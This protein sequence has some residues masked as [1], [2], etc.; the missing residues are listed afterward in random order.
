MAIEWAQWK[1]QAES[2][3]N[4]RQIRSDGET[5]SRKRIFGFHSVE[6]L[7]RKRLDN[8]KDFN[9]NLGSLSD[10]QK[11]LVAEFGRAVGQAVFNQVF[12][13]KIQYARPISASDIRL[14]D[15]LGK[16]L[17]R[18][19]EWLASLDGRENAEK[20]LS[21]VFHDVLIEDVSRL[22]PEKLTQLGEQVSDR[23]QIAK[24]LLEDDRRSA[25]QVEIGG[26]LQNKEVLTSYLRAAILL[27]G[28]DR[29]AF[30]EDVRTRF[31]VN[32][33]H[34]LTGSAA[35]TQSIHKQIEA[36]IT[37]YEVATAL[38][39]TEA[40]LMVRQAALA[41]SV[42][43]L[44]QEKDEVSQ[45]LGQ[46]TERQAEK[47]AAH[48]QSHEQ[49][50]LK[51]TALKELEAQIKAFDVEDK[52]HSEEFQRQLQPSFARLEA[53]SK[54]VAD[55]AAEAELLQHEQSELRNQTTLAL[56]QL[57]ERLEKLDA[58]SAAEK[59]NVKKI[60]KA[61]AKLEADYQKVVKELS[62]KI[63]A[64]D[65]TP[66]KGS[67]YSKGQRLDILHQRLDNASLEKQQI[68]LFI[69]DQVQKRTSSEQAD[70]QSSKLADLQQSLYAAQKEYR[71]LTEQVRADAQVVQFA[72]T[73][74][75]QMSQQLVEVIQKLSVQ[76]A[77][78]GLVEHELS[79]VRQQEA[80]EGAKLQ[81]AVGGGVG[82]DT[83]LTDVVTEMVADH[84]KISLIFSGRLDAATLEQPELE[85]L[86]VATDQ[87]LLDHPVFMSAS[88]SP[89][90]RLSRSRIEEALL[91]QLSSERLALIGLGDTITQEQKIRLDQLNSLL[92]R[93]PELPLPT[94]LKADELVKHRALE[95]EARVHLA[96]ALSEIRTG[97]SAAEAALAIPF[98]AELRRALHQLLA[99]RQMGGL[100]P[101]NTNL[102]AEQAL[103]DALEETAL[104]PLF[105]NDIRQTGQISV[106]RYQE[107][108]TEK[109]GEAAEILE[110]RNEAT[111]ALTN[112]RNLYAQNNQQSTSVITEQTRSEAEQALIS[113][114]EITDELKAKHEQVQEAQRLLQKRIQ[115][116]QKLEH[117]DDSSPEYLKLY[118]PFLEQA[119]RDH[120]AAVLAQKINPQEVDPIEEVSKQ[121]ILSQ[122]L[123]AKAHAVLSGAHSEGAAN[124]GDALDTRNVAVT[125]SRLGFKTNRTL[126]DG[127]CFYH[128][129]A[130]Q[131]TTPLTVA[132]LRTQVADDAQ[133]VLDALIKNPKGLPP[134]LLYELTPAQ[135]Q[136]TRTE[137]SA[138]SSSAEQIASWGE[139][140]H[141]AYVARVTNRPVVIFT[142][143]QGMLVY[144]KGQPQR[145]LNYAVRSDI[146]HNAILLAHNGSDHWE[147]VSLAENQLPA[148]APGTVL[149]GAPSTDT[150]GI[151]EAEAKRKLDE[152]LKK[153]EQ[154]SD[155]LAIRARYLNPPAL[156]APTDKTPAG[157][158]A[159]LSSG[160][161]DVGQL[162]IKELQGFLS[163][164]GTVSEDVTVPADPKRALE[165]TAFKLAKDALV[166]KVQT[167]LSRT[168]R[169]IADNKQQL[170]QSGWNSSAAVT[171]ARLEAFLLRDK[172]ARDNL[173]ALES[174]RKQLAALEFEREELLKIINDSYEVGKANRHEY[175]LGASLSLL[176]TKKDYDPFKSARQ[177]VAEKSAQR[178]I[179]ELRHR[180]LLVAKQNGTAALFDA[181]SQALLEACE[182]AQYAQDVQKHLLE[183]NGQY[184][185]YAQALHDAQAGLK[186][187]QDQYNPIYKDLMKDRALIERYEKA[188]TV[189]KLALS[190]SDYTDAVENEKRERAD[191][192]RLMGPLAS[193]ETLVNEINRKV[194]LSR[195]LNDKYPDATKA[196]LLN[197]AQRVGASAP[198][199]IGKV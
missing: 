186:Q 126:A 83:N 118:V 104:L 162:S 131:L 111:L 80:Q 91:P 171:N 132:Q 183:N 61:K 174:H 129:V 77:D 73:H 43:G 67:E 141:G 120:A 56:T 76:A 134:D 143:D 103:E 159:Y 151:S 169:A 95:S 189:K 16:N 62:K 135:I 25:A 66:Q 194:H 51:E 173:D 127:N 115:L 19:L 199:I 78:L 137:A 32:N 167:E 170:N 96:R 93:T 86:L 52:V 81:F 3:V 114:G 23:L 180:Q 71:D 187:W 140:D 5:I 34:P 156:Q 147:S 163:T 88:H 101:G 35:T 97:Q 109:Q 38:A 49:L 50:V 26:Y 138:A 44:E 24:T 181:A 42:Q 153:L 11:S 18:G 40:A 150:T 57:Q 13:T 39:D 84:A 65:N 145:L 155:T 82:P 20:A 124:D 123:R 122:A 75:D 63:Q 110:L 36:V 192:D 152:S 55:Y 105:Q 154:L 98:N 185:E 188:G 69:Q 28:E 193:A 31:G 99:I 195:L 144:E 70:S 37:Q 54:E 190:K 72:A 125:L 92:N 90:W 15:S 45:V 85:R 87:V 136:A 47:A 8:A 14:A 6:Q 184:P 33:L 133:A 59:P 64:F 58:T 22:S 128:A 157:L 149:P 30:L 197:N 168:N 10:I 176:R 12:L 17:T 139:A 9:A 74:V 178:V 142:A 29:T 79:V 102:D 89:F 112:L 2:A 21:Q 116:A 158:L 60:N 148:F 175:L 165:L 106:Q 182:V 48:V 161:A 41:A 27:Q 108:L 119:R 94:G 191:L 1:N 100:Y 130:V 68:E 7:D 160:T 107:V 164:L 177:I 4:A 121:P 198:K 196:Y 46:A 117:I 179:D 172:A 53:L 113:I 146:P 166:L